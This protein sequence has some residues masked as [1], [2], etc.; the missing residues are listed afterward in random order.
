MLKDEST[1]YI[2]KASSSKEAWDSLSARYNSHGEEHVVE[3]ITQIFQGTFS[4][5]KPLEPQIKAITKASHTLEEL[6]TMFN[7][8]TLAVAIITSLSPSLATLKVILSQT[9]S[10]QLMLAFITEKIRLDEHHR[11]NE[12]GEMPTAFFTKTGKKTND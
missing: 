12:S 7:D 3:L 9:S 4:E 1:H 8:A 5:S 10:V 2:E 6:G 11:I